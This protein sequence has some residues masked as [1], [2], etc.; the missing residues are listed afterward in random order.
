MD[1]D[2]SG[3][4]KPLAAGSVRL[5]TVIFRGMGGQGSQMREYAGSNVLADMKRQPTVF[6]HS[7][8]LGASKVLMSQGKMQRAFTKGSNISSASPTKVHASLG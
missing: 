6:R 4:D 2:G 8:L 1:R 7:D 5:A 3:S